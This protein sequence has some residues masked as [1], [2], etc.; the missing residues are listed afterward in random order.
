M[1]TGFNCLRTYSPVAALVDSVV[2]VYVIILGSKIAWTCRHV[3]KS[4]HGMTK[5]TKIDI[6][7]AARVSNLTMINCEF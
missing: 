6:F 5:E 1:W 3:P 4:P 2:K 7:T